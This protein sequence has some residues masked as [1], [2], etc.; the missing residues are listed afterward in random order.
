M[1]TLVASVKVNG[2]LHAMVLDQ[3][4]SDRNMLIF[5]NTYDSPENGQPKRYE[6]E[7]DDPNAPE[8]FYFVHIGFKNLSKETPDADITDDKSNDSYSTNNY[9]I[10][11]DS[12]C[13]IL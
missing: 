3:F 2:Q 6:I 10:E 8:E 11:P 5:K 1:Y 9:E 7:V 4:D 12:C 13:T